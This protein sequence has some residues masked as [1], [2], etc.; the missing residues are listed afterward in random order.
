M[1]SEVSKQKDV[2]TLDLCKKRRSIE[3]VCFVI[4]LLGLEFIYATSSQEM[5]RLHGAE[6]RP[7]SRD[8]LG[9]LHT[10]RQPAPDR[11]AHSTT[12]GRRGTSGLIDAIIWVESRG[13]AKAVGDNGEAVGILQIHRVCVDDVNRILGKDQYTYADRLNVEKSRQ[14]FGIYSAFYSKYHKDWSQQ[15]IARRWNGG[16]WG[17]RKTATWD[18]WLK[19]KAY[20]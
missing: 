19:V 7:V 10:T 18:Y 20:L 17:H 9:Q 15:G 3:S 6:V 4:I 16:P 8:R 12:D 1:E 14:M 2:C 11:V 5:P 13:N